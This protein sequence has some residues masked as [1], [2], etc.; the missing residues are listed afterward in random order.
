METQIATFAGGCF[1]CMQPPYD[2]LDGVLSTAVGYIGG[3]IENPDYQSVCSGTTG[4]TEAV[5]ITFDPQ[6]VS[7]QTLL[8]VFWKNI[9]PTAKNRQFADVGTQYRTGIFYHNPEQK[10]MAEESK[11]SLEQS[12]KFDQP[13]VP[14]ITEATTFYPAEEYHQAYYKKNEL[15]YTMYKKGSGRE[16]YL[17]ETWRNS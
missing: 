8:D 10:K 2:H 11:L 14:E 4:H 9:D 15:H 5:Q 1:W 16:G 3:Q 17:Q 13:I 6:K 12:K 7:Y